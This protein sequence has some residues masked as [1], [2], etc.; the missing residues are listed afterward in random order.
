MKGLLFKIA[1]SCHKK[2]TA[3]GIFLNIFLLEKIKNSNHFQ[4]NKK[5]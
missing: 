3:N 1:L 5:N 2:C 4:L